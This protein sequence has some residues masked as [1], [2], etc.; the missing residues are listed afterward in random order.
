MNKTA[1]ES[2]VSWF[3]IDDDAVLDLKTV[4]PAMGVWTITLEYITLADSNVNNIALSSGNASGATFAIVYK[5]SGVSDEAHWIN[6]GTT[7]IGG[8]KALSGQSLEQIPFT[9]EF[10]RIYKFGLLSGMTPFKDAKAKLHI[11]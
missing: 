8:T 2:G 4:K 10:G 6:S 1:N 11:Q 5:V 3:Q 9:P 7:I